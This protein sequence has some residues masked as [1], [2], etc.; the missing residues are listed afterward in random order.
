MTETD[1]TES[2]TPS[3]DRRRFLAL[4]AGA[5]GVAALTG[6]AGNPAPASATPRQDPF[7]LGVTSGEP[8]PDAVVIW[9]RLAVDP[10]AEDGSGGMPPVSSLVI[11]QVAETPNFR[12]VVRAGSVRTGPEVGHSVHVDVDRLR[13]GREYW[14]RF[15]VGRYVSPVGRTKTAPAAGTMPASMKFAFASCQSFGVGWFTPYEHVLADDPDLVLFLGDYIYCQPAGPIHPPGD[16]VASR[17]LAPARHCASIGDFRA[18]YATYRTDEHLQEAHRMLPWSVTIDDNEIDNNFWDDPDPAMVSLRTIGFQA[19]WENM[20]LLPSARPTGASMP[21]AYRRLRYGELATFHMLDTRQYRDAEAESKCAPEERPE[22]YCPDRLDPDRSIM[23]D[24]QESWLLDGLSSSR[25][26][27]NVLGNQVAFTQRDRGKKPDPADRNLST[28]GWDGYVADR[29]A[30]L[31]RLR[32]E[33][34]TNLIVV[35]GDSHSNWVLNTP[36]DYKSWDAGIAPVCT[37]FMVTSITSGGE[38][39]PEP[40]YQPQPQNPQLLYHDKSHGYG[41]TT[42][43]PDQCRTDYRAVSTIWSPTSTVETISSWVVD[44]HTPG[45]RRA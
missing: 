1:S 25:T 44:P 10:L 41:L 3:L 5:V 45:A 34:I 42:L 23:G 29:Q 19:F 21:G 4:G 38:R 14:Y 43:T 30:I 7:T 8:R 37:E 35:T 40:Q 16:P 28:N 12:K 13:P 26:A 33:D 9:T 15:R 22:G 39:D 32:T 27:W 17:I 24:E 6:I 31:D 36:P 18:R 11:W 2:E 20:P